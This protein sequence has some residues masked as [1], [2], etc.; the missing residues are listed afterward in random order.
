MLPELIDKLLALDGKQVTALT[1]DDLEHDVPPYEVQGI[2]TARQLPDRI[3]PWV[4]G[5]Q[6]D[7][8]TVKPKEEPPRPTETRE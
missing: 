4:N 5:V 8:A 3:Q 6:V 2:L 1:Y 7:P